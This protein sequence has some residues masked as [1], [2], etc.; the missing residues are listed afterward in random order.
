MLDVTRAH[1]LDFL[2][3]QND[4]TIAAALKLRG[5]FAPAEV[6][7]IAAYLGADAEG[8]LVD[9]GANIGAISL[10]IARANPRLKVLGIEAHRGL[11]QVLSANAFGNHLYNVSVLNAAVG[12]TSGIVDFPSIALDAQGNFGLLGFS[13]RTGQSERVRMCSLD[14]VA[15]VTTRFVKVDVEGHEP[16]V[17]QG[18]VRLMETVRPVWLLEANLDTQDANI[19]ARRLLLAADY[20]LY[21]FYSPIMRK[22]ET[23]KVSKEPAHSRGDPG[24]VA[25]PRGGP[26]LWDL[27]RVQAAEESPPTSLSDYA[28]LKRYG[29]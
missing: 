10:P 21:W 2:F 14:E 20:D 8:T 17:V 1:G 19:E 18:A 4:V 9:V 23:P 24:V 29:F 26:N 7:L 28:Y 3:P 11:A 13:L 5:E 25:V 6:D 15:P 22:G 27:P 16:A 12:K